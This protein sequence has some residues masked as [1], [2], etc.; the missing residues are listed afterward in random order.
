[1][2]TLRDLLEPSGCQGPAAVKR[3]ATFYRGYDV[4]DPVKVGFVS[5]VPQENGRRFYL[6]DTR[7][8]GN[9]NCGHEGKRFGTE[10]RPR[11]KDAIVE[12]LKTF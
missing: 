1:M 7:L 11:E 5:T 10:L 8:D 2:P 9:R 6:Y 12:Y 3:P 4:I